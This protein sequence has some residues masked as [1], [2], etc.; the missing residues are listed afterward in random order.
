MPNYFST[1]LS[2]PNSMTN[3]WIQ[4]Y[5][6]L[7]LSYF[8]I[9]RLLITCPMFLKFFLHSFSAHCSLI[10]EVIFNYRMKS[11]FILIQIILFIISFDILPNFSF[12]LYWMTIQLNDVR[13][14][15]KYQ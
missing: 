9:Y 7:Y 6:V 8:Q 14:L 2:H 5:S 10:I 11:Y 4:F 1:C 15:S 3:I 12:S 13:Y